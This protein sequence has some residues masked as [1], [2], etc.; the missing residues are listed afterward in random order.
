MVVKIK[1]LPVEERPYE[2]MIS[3]GASKLTNEE[4]ISILIKSGT[5]NYSAKELA[6]ILLKNINN[7]SDLNN[8]SYKELI[9]ISGIGIKKS[10]VLL[11]AIEL[12][13]RVN[14][15]TPSIIS[16]KLN[17]SQIVFEYYRNLLKDTKQEHFYCVY[18]DNSKKIIYEKLLFLGTI[19]YSVVHPR[20]I[21]K[22]AY[23]YSASAILCVHNHPSNNLF[24]SPEDLKITR[25]IKEV[26]E[27]L[28]IKVLD[29]IIIGKNSYYSF[30][31]N[32]DI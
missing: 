25:N 17:S 12:G 3:L 10:C 1:E 18:L 9:Q 21:F 31:E 22:E 15:Y 13:K 24:P 32:G 2:K 20:E 23:R 8:I 26:G 11:A 16:K 28:G 14:G 5:K 29:H 30:L 4:L 19:N 7:I 6:T 27:L